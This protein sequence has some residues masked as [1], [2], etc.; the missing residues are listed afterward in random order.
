[1][2]ISDTIYANRLKQTMSIFM[3][4]MNSYMPDDVGDAVVRYEIDK[5]T[6]P[7]QIYSTVTKMMDPKFKYGINNDNKINVTELQ[8]CQAIQKS[9]KA[10]MIY[11][12]TKHLRKFGK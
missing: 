12:N 9:A 2:Q 4:Y 6:T 7:D 5:G 3:P 8:L 11:K 1:M 10:R